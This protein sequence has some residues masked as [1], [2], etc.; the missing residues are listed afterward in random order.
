M[1]TGTPSRANRRRVPASFRLAYE[2]RLPEPEVLAGAPS[3]LSP[4][5]KFG[6]LPS[7]NR[8]VLGDNLPVMLS[9]LQD[10]AVAGRAR[11]VYIDPP[12]S[13]GFSFES[14]HVGR[15]Y[16]DTLSGAEYLEA[17]RRRLIVLRELMASDGSIYVHL[18]RNMVFP[19]KLLMD[20][21][22]GDRNFR[23][24]ITRVKCNPKN[25]TSRQFGDECDYL[26]FYTKSSKHV[27][28]HPVEPWPE[29]AGAREYPYVEVGTGRRYKK[30]PCHLPGTRQGATGQE[31][32][33]R[34]PP[35]GKHWV[36]SPERL[37]ELDREGRIYWSPS[38]N[39]RR[40][41]YLDEVEGRRLPNFWATFRD[42]QNQNARVTGF[43]TEKNREML[44]MIVCASSDPEDLVLDAYA[45]SGT[46]LEAAGLS[47]RKWIGIDNS[48]VAIKTAL[49]RLRLGTTRMGSY[50][51]ANYLSHQLQLESIEDGRLDGTLYVDASNQVFMEQMKGLVLD[52]SSE[53]AS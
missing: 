21:L 48:V 14:S 38:G 12:Y 43:P 18:D 34:K 19:V 1:A 32:R 53:E 8:L 39:P 13:T 3:S 50:A 51:K 11:L 49:S 16:D 4:F 36:H 41:L 26:L 25:Y 31:W 15:A 6:R 9:L 30:V 5:F 10:P 37:D 29:E 27:W 35:P 28:N 2:G 47:H 40:K 46:A 42:T 17:L 7:P 23:N 24:M 20:E 45:G 33:G 52:E 44:Q 22:F